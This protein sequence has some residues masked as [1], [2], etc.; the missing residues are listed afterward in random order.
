MK[1]VSYDHFFTILGNRQRV[2]I[3]QYLNQEGPK[4]VSDISTKLKIEQSAVSHCMKQLLLCH[5]VEV[6]QQGKERIYS[7]NKDT[8]HPLFN[9]INKHVESYCAEGCN[10][11]E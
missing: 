3:L 6:T 8:M 10:H 5:F 1:Y 9:L 4:S 2:R 7:I 11:W